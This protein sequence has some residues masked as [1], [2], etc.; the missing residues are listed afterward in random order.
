MEKLRLRDPHLCVP[1]FAQFSNGSVSINAAT[2]Q[3][4]F[5]LTCVPLITAVGCGIDY[6]RATQIRSKLQAAADAASV[7]SIA[8]NSP[9][10]LAAGTMTADGSIAAGVTDAKNI[11]DAN[12][13]NQNGYTLTSVT[14]VVSK[15]GSTVTSTVNFSA[16]INTMFLGVIGKSTVAM[17]GTSTATASMP[18][19][20]DFYLLLDNS[21]SMGVAATPTDITNLQAKTGGYAHS[22]VT[23]PP[24]RPAQATTTLPKQMASLPESTWC[25]RRART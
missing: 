14:P 20:I 15:T 2:S 16:T 13:A 9:A 6:S 11:F 22:R 4:I 24:R 8:K 25:A 3:L 7:G 12:R 1:R 23:T 21:P 17:S 10:F 5:A 19:Y 18:L